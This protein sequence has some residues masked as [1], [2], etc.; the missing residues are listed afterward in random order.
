MTGGRKDGELR[1]GMTNS[2]GVHA[3]PPD[4]GQRGD[5]KNG[6]PMGLSKHWTGNRSKEADHKN[7]G[8]LGWA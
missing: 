6:K 4:A 1:N 5:Y 3:R 2:N 8:Q 7:G